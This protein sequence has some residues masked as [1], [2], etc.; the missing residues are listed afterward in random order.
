MEH[1]RREPEVRAQVAGK[2]EGRGAR[3]GNPSLLGRG[4]RD[5]GSRSVR[6]RGSTSKRVV[7]TNLVEPEV[8]ALH[9][10]QEGQI[11]FHAKQR[12]NGSTRAR[13]APEDSGRAIDHDDD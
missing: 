6:S 3:P 9:P 4:G 11:G 2:A 5:G 12:F 8:L 7:G 13:P 1:D 10:P